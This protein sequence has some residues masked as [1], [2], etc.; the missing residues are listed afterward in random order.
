MPRPLAL[1]VGDEVASSRR[2]P[3]CAYEPRG[4][5]RPLSEWRVGTKNAC[6]PEGLGPHALR[7]W[8]IDEEVWD[9]CVGVL[10]KHVET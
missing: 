6:W 3:P 4:G 2:L 9:P 5:S 8:M 1:N 7:V 10:T